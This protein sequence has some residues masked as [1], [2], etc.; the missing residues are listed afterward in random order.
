VIRDRVRVARD[1]R[2]RDRESWGPLVADMVAGAHSDHIETLGTIK[3]LAVLLEKDLLPDNGRKFLVK[4]LKTVGN[5]ANPIPPRK[6][7]ARRYS[8][9]RVLAAVEQLKTKGLWLEEVFTEVGR[10]MDMQP[11]TVK[12]CASQGRTQIRKVVARAGGDRDLIVA[13]IANFYGIPRVTF[14]GLFEK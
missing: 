11:S 6:K 13:T 9:L 7:A 3:F 12:K 10:Q 1:P 14:S 4:F 5:G 8:N 2:R